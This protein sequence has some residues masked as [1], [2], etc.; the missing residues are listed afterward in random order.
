MPG[1]ERLRD[2]RTLTELL[3]Q[4]QAADRFYSAICAAPAVVLES[5]GLL[6]GKKATSHPGFSDK[7][8]DQ[9]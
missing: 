9:R 8:S 3:E 5:K 1:A 7:L 6:K 4:Q 2:S